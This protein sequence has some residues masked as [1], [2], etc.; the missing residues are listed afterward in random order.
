MLGVNRALGIPGRAAGVGDGGGSQ[1]VRTGREHR[2][3]GCQEPGPLRVPGGVDDQVP[4]DLMLVFH[5]ARLVDHLGVADEQGRL[6]VA[7]QVRLFGS[8]ECPVDAHPD[9]TQAHDAM[10]E[11]HNREI[12]AERDAH[13]VPGTDASGHQSPHVAG[14]ELIELGVRESS[15]PPDQR[16]GIRALGESGC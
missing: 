13:P 5:L 14:G 11:P 2:P 8:S 3:I 6:T 15:A 7:Q 10:E 16:F 9:G 1:R 12:V 4:P